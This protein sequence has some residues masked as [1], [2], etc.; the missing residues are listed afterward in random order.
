[1]VAFQQKFSKCTFLVTIFI[2]FEALELKLGLINISGGISAESHRVYIFSYNL[3]LHSCS[4]VKVR[5]NVCGCISAEEVN[6]HILSYNLKLVCG[7]GGKIRLN[8]CGG[9]SAQRQKV[10]I[11]NYNLELFLWL[12]SENLD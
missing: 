11:L 7:S 10:Y 8:V 5:L 4:G 9:I 3:E 12:W 1:M 6:V 2:F